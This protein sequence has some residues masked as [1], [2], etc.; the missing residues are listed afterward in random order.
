LPSGKVLA[1]VPGDHVFETKDF[2]FKAYYVSN[3][4]PKYEIL[5]LFLYN[6]LVLKNVS[7]CDFLCKTKNQSNEPKIFYNLI[8]G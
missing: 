7:K 6:D 2:I 1:A 8:L 3:F 5:L 4:E